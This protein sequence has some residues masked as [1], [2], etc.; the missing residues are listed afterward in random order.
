[1]H[2]RKTICVW[3]DWEGVI[4]Y[5]MLER[6]KAVNADL[7]IEQMHRLNDAIQQKRPD[8][9]Q[10]L[11]QHDNVRPHIANITNTAIQTLDWEV[12]PHPLYSPDLV[13]SDYHLFRSLSNA[14]S[15]VSF[16]NDVKLKMWLN[17][18]FKSRSSGFYK[19]GIEKLVEHWQEVVNNEGKYIID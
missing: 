9:R 19:R 17:E 15:G 12:L 18:F 16:N 13:P 4:H 7:Y 3:W 11:L 1:L 14:M 2:P 10:G 6:N 8:R 5:E